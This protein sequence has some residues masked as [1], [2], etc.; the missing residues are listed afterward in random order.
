MS[1]SPDWLA[2]RRDAD[3]RARCPELARRLSTRFSG[4]TRVLDLGSGTGANM[5]ATA[6]LLGDDQS[7]VL[8]DNDATLLDRAVAPEGVHLSRRVVDLAV[9]LESLFNPAPDLVTASAFF[10]LCGSGLI[11]RVV[12]ATVAAGPVSFA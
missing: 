3:D 4:P 11:G 8:A 5:I 6:P 10:D 1:F 9:D 12:A 7:W 2:L